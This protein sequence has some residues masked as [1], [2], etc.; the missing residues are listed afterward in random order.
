MSFAESQ[1]KAG[2]RFQNLVTGTGG[3]AVPGKLTLNAN[4]AG[5]LAHL[6]AN[7]EASLGTI[8]RGGGAAGAAFASG[9]AAG[10]VTLSRDAETTTVSLKTR[11]D[12]NEMLPVEPWGGKL[13][14]APARLRNI[15]YIPELGR[16]VA[17]GDN[18]LQSS[19]DGETWSSRE[20]PAPRVWNKMAWSAERGLL[21]VGAQF[22][23]ASPMLLTSTDGIT[24]STRTTPNARSIN[25]IAYGA[26]TFATVSSTGAPM[27][28]T[29]G[30]A[31]TTRTQPSVQTWCDLV[32]ADSLGLFVALSTSGP[33]H[34]M[35]SPDGINWTLRPTPAQSGGGLAPWRAL[36]WSPARGVLVAVASGGA[37]R[38]MTSEDGATWTLRTVPLA[39][40]TAVTWADEIGL[41]VAVARKADT[42]GDALM[43]TSPDGVTW[44]TR[45]SSQVD[46]Y[47]SVG[48]GNGRLLAATEIT[49]GRYLDEGERTWHGSLATGTNWSMAWSPELN[50]LVTSNRKYS[51]D[52]G[53]TWPAGTGSTG[54]GDYFTWAAELGIF[55]LPIGISASNIILQ[56]RD[57]RSWS[58][59]ANTPVSSTW[60]DVAWSPERSTFVVLSR[61]NTEIAVSTTAGESW[62]TITPIVH[63]GGDY[64]NVIWVPELQSFFYSASGAVARSTDGLSWESIAVPGTSVLNGFAWSAEL[65][66]LVVTEN[67]GKIAYSTTGG[68]SWSSVALAG[69]W[70]AAAWSPE[71]RF[72]VAVGQSS[73]PIAYS[74]DGIN[75]FTETAAGLGNQYGVLWIPELARFVRST[76]SGVTTRLE[77]TGRMR[78][79]YLQ[80][81]TA[82]RP[83][84]VQRS[85]RSGAIG[86]AWSSEHDV[87]LVTSYNQAFVSRSTTGG[88]SWETVAL[89]VSE[90]WW[91]AAWAPEISTFVL[92]SSALNPVA[93]STDLGLTWTTHAKSFSITRVKWVPTGASS[94]KFIGYGTGPVGESSDGGITWTS[95]SGLSFNDFAYS[96][97]LSVSIAV[98]NA[99][100]LRST[101]AW[102]NWET[103]SVSGG[104]WSAVVWMPE[105]NRFLTTATASLAYSDDGGLTWT[106]QA[107]TTTAQTYRHLVW[108]PEISTVFGGAGTAVNTGGIISSR[109]G[110]GSPDGLT[111]V[112]DARFPSPSSTEAVYGAEWLGAPHYR[113]VVA[114][115]GAS[116]AFLQTYPTADQ[117]YPSYAL[118]AKPK[119]A[120]LRRFAFDPAAPP[121]WS[122]ER[123]SGSWQGAV[124]A[125]ELG[126][127]VIVATNV[128]ARSTTGGASWINS[129]PLGS[130]NAI[131]WAPEIN[132]FVA[133]GNSGRFAYSTT[134]ATSWVTASYGTALWRNV[135]WAP[136]IRTWL[137][138]SST[139][140]YARSTDNGVT[141]QTVARTNEWFGI[142]WA[143]EIRTFVK[144][145]FSGTNPGISYS[146][147][148][149]SSWADA[150]VMGAALF[151]VAWSSELARFVAVGSN[152]VRIST[153]GGVSWTNGTMP[154]GTWYRVTWVPELSAFIAV[155][156]AGNA[157]VS[158]TGGESWVQV[159]RPAYDSWGVAWA[160]E[161]STLLSPSRS[162]GL[163]RMIIPSSAAATTLAL[164]S[165]ERS[166]LT[167]NAGGIVSETSSPFTGSHEVGMV[168]SISSLLDGRIAVTTGK[169]RAITLS[170]SRPEAALATL[171]YDRRVYGV[172]NSRGGGRPM[173]NAVGEGGMWVCDAG[174]NL[175][176]GDYVCS[177]AVAGYGM[178]QPEPGM[179][180]YTVAKVM[181]PCRFEE[182]AAEGTHDI[183]YLAWAEEYDRL[184]G[185]GATAPATTEGEATAPGTA[186]DGEATASATTEG[187]ATAPAT[188]E[189]EATAPATTEGEATAPTT[190][191]GEATAPATTEGEATAP[192][193]TE[194]EAT[195]PATTE[196]EATAP[197]TTEG[198]ATALT[199]TEGE[200]T[201]PATTEGEATAQATTEGEATAPTTTEGEA[202]APTTTEGEA[203]AP[204]TTEGEATAPTTTEGEA[205]APATTEGEATA[206]ATTKGEATAEPTS[207][208]ELTASASE[209]V[210]V[211]KRPEPPPIVLAWPACAEDNVVRISR[212]EYER[213]IAAGLDAFRA[214]FVG[215]TYHCG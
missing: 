104:N 178:R 186:T 132:T 193:T 3:L 106:V 167:V 107:M 200:A 210:T 48:W 194:G 142:S 19:D 117:T 59:F 162:N 70:R 15:M 101:D 91:G 176:T 163:F 108:A 126:M 71:L 102:T 6:G 55:V 204:A 125:K 45:G 112:T 37:G 168:G 145:A 84:W 86:V 87:L 42:A 209:P 133:G 23:A 129:S 24:Y 180:N 123:L 80:D 182:A 76:A 5:S 203:T 17:A 185:I 157:A 33:N 121:A 50:T 171:P 113:F 54:S 109:I 64:C 95:I 47:R 179:R 146:T 150:S 14:Q 177:S 83:Q 128:I 141:W 68:D 75:W 61:S 99:S 208:G 25:G 170:D 43:M 120:A 187:E 143:P 1:R 58:L 56:S 13:L 111:W 49:Q 154:S 214:V 31:W 148:S 201:A 159:N 21:V 52:G 183:R 73:A 16:Y 39:Q 103:Q 65:N 207:E 134:G 135:A 195:A 114:V 127:F 93:R 29:D 92:G 191:E 20:A 22:E 206:P 53:V 196:G 215:C 100:I 181:E 110:Y 44:T 190:T 77:Y 130:W 40:W 9:A 213:R 118:A 98:A 137:G 51:T 156:N 10:E 172:F 189:G 82:P 66:T 164:T 202:T 35:T 97:E 38:V 211:V 198:E 161:L 81:S 199:T 149:G 197:A 72:F 2:R 90:L 116:S 174:G 173:V 74:T 184:L 139:G 192:P 32:W 67:S 136:E 122:D 79:L 138:V 96:P 89:P 7:D 41:F 46:A 11:V 34:V 36:V 28:S 57:G 105:R 153:T 188:T 158:T 152:V 147:T 140:F 212:E 169:M 12:A 63:N 119:G 8:V 85:G 69:S 205:T 144:V 60:C 124:Y 165:G 94:G 131:A 78:D 115:Y 151:G 175:A 30:V 166:V 155:G 4:A 88:V 18:A 62:Q 27:T 160:P 26:G